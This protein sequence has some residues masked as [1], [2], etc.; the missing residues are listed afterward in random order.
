LLPNCLDGYVGEDYP[1]RAIEAFV[2]QLDLRKMGFTPQK[3]LKRAYEQRPEAVQNGSMKNTRRSKNV[4][5]PKGEI[6]WSDETALVNTDV[7][8]RCYAPAGQTPVAYAVG[9]RHAG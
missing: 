1:V 6:H 7:R 8:G 9:G 2:E 4:P 5:K 3:P